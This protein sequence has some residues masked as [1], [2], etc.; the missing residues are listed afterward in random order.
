MV[1]LLRWVLLVTAWLATSGSPAIG[2]EA[3]AAAA[4]DRYRWDFPAIVAY[5]DEDGASHPVT[6]VRKDLP[7][8]RRNGRE[9]HPDTNQFRFERTDIYQR[10]YIEILDTGFDEL[11]VMHGAHFFVGD[12]EAGTRGRIRTLIRPE[13]G[14][15][16]LAAVL[17][18]YREIP[19]R[20]DLNLSF[21]SKVTFNSIGAVEA[22]VER[23]L[24]LFVDTWGDFDPHSRLLLLFYE[25][26]LPIRT[27]R[28]REAY[29]YL[30]EREAGAHRHIL[31]AYLAH[32]GETDRTADHQI[33]L[34]FTPYL[35]E[36]VY[37]EV[38]RV[39][40]YARFVI[41]RQGLPQDIEIEGLS[42]SSASQYLTWR[43]A[44]WRFLPRL[45]DGQPVPQTLRVP[46][47][48]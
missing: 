47:A 38:G 27:N 45:V 3:D 25:Q 20:P 46:I 15:R 8:I 40:A 37:R 41:D 2:G 24:T 21:P 9:S 30:R 34:A 42:H 13:T 43:I 16:N 26:G 39:K 18:A 31:R 44:E 48:Y 4:V 17:V 36:P 32:A 5:V 12:Q 33:F 19:E 29:R 6:K 7:V 14:F 23:R 10:G 28:D 1:R 22:G 11:E 35:P